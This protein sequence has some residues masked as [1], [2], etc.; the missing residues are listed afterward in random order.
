MYL[1]A[2]LR[3]F[4]LGEHAFVPLRE[5]SLQGPRRANLRQGVSRGEREGLSFDILPSQHVSPLM[6]EL[7]RVSD[8]WLEHHRAAEKSFSLGAFNPDY[9]RRQPVGLALKDGHVVAFTTLLATARR[10]DASVDLMRQLPDAPKGTMD[11]LLTKTM[12]HFRD[13]GFERFGLGMA[14]LSG[15]AEHPLASRWHRW[16]RLLFNYGEYFYNFQGLRSFKEKFD[17]VWEPRYLAT[18]GGLPLMT[19]ADIA[20]LISGGLRAAVSK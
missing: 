3:L 12:L 4:K 14:P 19:L 11:Y 20:L 17:P 5:F 18:G 6:P 2:G 15:M 7:Q 10:A 9:I 13:Q 1:D 8:A 16:G